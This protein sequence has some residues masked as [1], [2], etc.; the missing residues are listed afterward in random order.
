MDIA[1]AI[2]IPLEVL[3][4]QLAYAMAAFVPD[5]GSVFLQGAFNFEQ[6]VRSVGC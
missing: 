2:L 3:F 4:Q 1:C 5:L 6:F